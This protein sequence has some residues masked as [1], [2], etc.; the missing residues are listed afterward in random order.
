MNSPKTPN[1][2]DEYICEIIKNAVFIED[3]GFICVY[4]I[5]MYNS[6]PVLA[7][8]DGE[9]CRIEGISENLEKVQKLVNRI[10]KY[11]IYP[12][13]LKDIVEDFLIL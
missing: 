8:A 12:I 2:Y 4:G 9:H 11:N 7:K 10:I 13:H 3:T 1:S 5:N 6:N